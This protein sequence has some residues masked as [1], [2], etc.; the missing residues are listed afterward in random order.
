MKKWY[1][2]L[3]IDGVNQ[4]FEDRKRKDSKFWNEGK[5]KTFIEPLLPKERQTFLEM[6]CNA[7][8]FLK[9]ATD[10]GF[11]RV[12]GI[13]ANNQIIAQA[14]SF[15][16]SNGYDYQLVYGRAGRGF[17]IETIALS[18]VVL[19]SNSHYYIPVGGFSKLVDA[20]KY[21]ALYCI[22]VSAHTRSRSGKTFSDL[23]SIR[24][25]FGDWE[26]VGL[27]DNISIEGD[28]APRES[29]YGVIF[30]SGLTA[31]E[32]E[33]YHSSWMEASKGFR[34]RS[35]KLAPAL[36]DFM[37]LALNSDEMDYESTDLYQYWR[38]RKP[39]RSE[40]WTRKM[41][42]YRHN[43]ALSIKKEGIKEPIYIDKKGKLLDGLHR[44]CIARALGYKHII[45]RIFK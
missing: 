22:I 7:G 33:G 35:Y 34:H 11:K 40:R 18:D 17:D 10:A 12:M 36:M 9:K 42:V 3:E 41:M 31:L 15:K 5:W 16:E 19:F 1:Q 4:T 29:M 45:A 26:E 44:L 13:E 38:K 27:I 32:I 39:T 43:L 37:D 25:Y 14:K 8:L 30:K 24:G 28:P 20:L 21:R 6:G 23:G 2:T